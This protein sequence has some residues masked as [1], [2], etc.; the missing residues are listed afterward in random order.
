MK[1]C[2]IIRLVIGENSDH[3]TPASALVMEDQRILIGTEPESMN[4]RLDDNRY[5]FHSD[6]TTSVCN[7][8]G[9]IIRTIPYRGPRFIWRKVHLMASDCSLPAN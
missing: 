5:I 6:P 4:G 9:R 2:Q 8:F 3:T 7:N 1:S